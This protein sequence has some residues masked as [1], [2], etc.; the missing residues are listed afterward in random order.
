MQGGAGRASVC[1][2]FGSSLPPA[3]CS[4]NILPSTSHTEGTYPLEDRSSLAK[5]CVH[6]FPLGR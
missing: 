6:R 5:A 1:G 4:L 3:P 2:R